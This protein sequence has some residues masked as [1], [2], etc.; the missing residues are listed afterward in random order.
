MHGFK[1]FEDPS[2]APNA[3]TAQND[4]GMKKFFKLKTY[5]VVSVKILVSIQ[6]VGLTFLDCVEK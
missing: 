3:V 2:R 6:K 5:I 4:P 1:R